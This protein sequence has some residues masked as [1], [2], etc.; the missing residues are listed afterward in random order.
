LSVEEQFLLKDYFNLTLEYL[1]NRDITDSE[2]MT[3]YKYSGANYTRKYLGL[4]QAKKLI[5]T[6]PIRDLNKI[7]LEKFK[8]II[9]LK[10]SLSLISFLKK[11]KVNS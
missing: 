1:R 11:N 4:S 10:D 6:F 2:F 9:K 5:E 8:E 3:T 7:Q